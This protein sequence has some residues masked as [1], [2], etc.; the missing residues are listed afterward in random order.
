MNKKITRT[1]RCYGQKVQCEY[2][3]N[4]DDLGYTQTYELD[5]EKVKIREGAIDTDK[6]YRF[7]VNKTQM[8]EFEESM[9]K[10]MDR[11]IHFSP[12]LKKKTVEV[13][14][15]YSEGKPFVL[16]VDGRVFF[17]GE[18]PNSKDFLKRMR[19]KIIP[20]DKIPEKK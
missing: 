11:I 19:E 17:T 16:K 9:E 7:F 15:V 1:E 2:E 5:V 20:G 12:D 10:L 14:E 6:K 18:M 3:F 13:K 4:T 8:K